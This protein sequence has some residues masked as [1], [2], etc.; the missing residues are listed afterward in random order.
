MTFNPSVLAGIPDAGIGA[1]TSL[2]VLNDDGEVLAINNLP[3]G[4][5]IKIKISLRSTSS[6]PLVCITYSKADN[7]WTT[8]GCSVSEPDAYG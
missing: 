5:E 8:E 2:D 7:K 1:I 6:E 4:K 3:A